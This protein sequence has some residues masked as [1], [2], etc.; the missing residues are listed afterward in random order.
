MI[1]FRQKILI[2]YIIALFAFGLLTIPIVTR[3]VRFIAAQAMEDRAD[4]V[5]A[6]IKTAPNVSAMINLLEEQRVLIFFRLSILTKQQKILF[7]SHKQTI[8]GENYLPDYIVNSPEVLE[9][10]KTGIGYEEG[11]S[12]LL[13]QRFSYLA[14][15]FDFHGKTYIIRTA[16][17]SKYFNDLARDCE[18]AFLAIISAILVLYSIITW[19]IIS[20]FTKPIQQIILAVSPY[21][22]G[23]QSYIPEI[24]LKGI[25]SRDEFNKLAITLNSLSSKVQKQIDTLTS[26][27]N[28]KEAIL[29]SLVEGVIA[30]ESD[31]T[32][33]Y[34]NGSA[35]R[36][37]QKKSQDLV[38]HKFSIGNES[39]SYSLIVRCQAELKALTDTITI[40]KSNGIKAFYDVVAAPIGLNR[41]AIFVMQDKSSHYKLLTMRK[42]FI[43]NASH[44]LKT[45]IT[46][47]QGFA[48]T[49][50]ENP[51]LPRDVQIDVTGKIVNNC[52]RMTYLI[53][54]LLTLSDIE[55]IPHSRL[56][57][58]DLHQIAQGCSDM[59]LNIYPDAQISIHKP[60]KL[61]MRLEAD[62]YLIERAM[63]NLIEN[64]IKYSEAP[65]KVEISMDKQDD[66]YKIVISDQGIGIPAADLEHIFERFYRVNRASK[67]KYAGFSSG[68]G[69][70]IVQ[71][72][73]HKHSG[74]IFVKSQVGVGTV[75]TILLPC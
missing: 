67:Q 37:L 14:K 19:L 39:D 21:Q 50:H 55:N 45:P 4:E 52:K 66:R 11:Y 41:G 58:C 47:I 46:I 6:K 26:E 33:T 7:D 8:L 65:A 42:E 27:R 61:E 10:L 43:A 73:I 44:E 49:L 60:N 23:K 56:V 75:F 12:N 20:H 32:V 28:E 1:S 38:G 59:L 70:S 63:F 64:A 34:A 31:M 69:L 36:I 13:Q 9:A 3:I 35:S 71:T 29:E 72:I 5:I 22:E 62:P 53:K 48:E 30:V 16:F 74:Q 15:T 18:V 57:D 68:L 40:V 2:S 54:D 25:N 17:P 51:D 24:K